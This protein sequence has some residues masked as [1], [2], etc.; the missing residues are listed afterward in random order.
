MTY[1]KLSQFKRQNLITKAFKEHNVFGNH[2]LQF[3]N[4]KVKF[5]IL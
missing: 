2:L 3:I 5:N 4:D 1:F